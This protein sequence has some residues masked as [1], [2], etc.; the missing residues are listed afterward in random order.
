MKL[1]RMILSGVLIA[2][3]VLNAQAG[4]INGVIQTPSGGPIRN[5]TLTLTLNQ[6]ANVPGTAQVVAQQ[7]QCFTDNFGNLVGEPDQTAAPS[8]TATPGPGTL[9]AGT[10][11]VK[12]A[13][14]D[15]SGVSNVS[16]EA[17][18]ILS[19]PGTLIVNAPGTQP[20]NA[21]GFR[22]YIGATSGSETL[23]GTVT[24]T[25]GTWANF[26]QAAALSAGS[27]MPV[28]N[29][30]VCTF[31]FTDSMIPSTT[32]YTINLVNA[33]G[34]KIAGYPISTVRFYGGTNGSVN[35]SN[36]WPISFGGTI[37][38]TPI[39]STPAANA[40]Q[41]I[42]G[43]LDLGTFPMKF[44]DSVMPEESTPTCS[45]GA[46][47]CMYNDSTLH[48]PEFINSGTR[49]AI[50]MLNDSLASFTGTFTSAQL[51]ALVTD[52]TGTG[53][54]VFANGGTIAP[55]SVTTGQIIQPAA[56]ALT[57]KDNQG[58]TRFSIPSG[59]VLQAILNNT[60]LMGASNSNAVTLL[61][62]QFILG[63]TTGNA[64][65]QPL[66]TY[67]LPANTLGAGKGIRIIFDVLINA[68]AT[69]FKLSFGGS[70]IY[71]FTTNAANEQVTGEVLIF[72]N[73]G[74]TNAQTFLARPAIGGT[75]IFGTT[76]GALA[77]ATTGS[78]TITLTGNCAAAN[79]MTPQ[80]WTV[81]L[82][83]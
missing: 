58:G 63:A 8:G 53:P 71:N 70:N 6:V 46:T 45:S 25:P 35:V 34:S 22:V 11:F 38:P 75:S 43:G 27:A 16:P 28:S 61:N 23:Q 59:G 41:S 77:I 68:A 30:T 7:V 81:E 49:S 56:T 2:L 73:A 79:T 44:G 72:N 19:G 50:A 39:I 54:L 20:A 57:I 74:V 65:D 62:A 51:A 47:A 29:T 83:Q 52:E 3:S 82:I 14:Q 42:A 24:G 12:T 55:T 1:L 66:Y 32:Y 5:G 17:S 48:R 80:M 33:Q 4:T 13:I 78:V 21:T 69:T 18:F 76:S 67:S 36:G 60:S 37:Y 10:Y 9:A 26:S 15:A 31:A 40:T 64:T